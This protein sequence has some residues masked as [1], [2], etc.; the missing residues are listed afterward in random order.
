MRK[1]GGPTMSPQQAPETRRILAVDDE[2]DIIESIVEQL[3]DY[4]VVAAKDFDTAHKLI[5]TER[6]DLAILDIMGVNG[7]TLLDLCCARGLPAAMLTAHALTIASIS[8]A[9]KLGAVS[10]LPKDELSRIS[11]HVGEI[12]ECLAEGKT[13]WE[14]LFQKLE[15]LFRQRLGVEWEHV[16][17]ESY[18]LTFA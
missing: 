11:E 4:S 15:P 6:F 7:F 16:G 5:V 9:M 12:F 10:F 14:K 2:P 8:L 3:E 13:H 18:P 1:E 17:K